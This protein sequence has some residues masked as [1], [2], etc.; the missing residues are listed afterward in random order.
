MDNKELA[1]LQTRY[2]KLADDAE[3]V[4]IEI[5]WVTVSGGLRLPV[6]VTEELKRRDKR[7]AKLPDWYRY[8]RTAQI[9]ENE[10]TGGEDNGD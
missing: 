8:S 2:N 6:Q 7:F 1:S 9:I 5:K 3:A 10:L 4:G